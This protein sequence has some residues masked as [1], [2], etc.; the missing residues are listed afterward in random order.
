MNTL[1]SWSADHAGIVFLY[2]DG[3]APAADL[4]EVSG[5]LNRDTAYKDD[6][7][8]EEQVAKQ[9]NVKSFLHL[10]KQFMNRAS[11]RGLLDKNGKAFSEYPTSF[12]KMSLTQQALV[13]EGFYKNLE[14]VS[15]R[16]SRTDNPH[17][18]VSGPQP[19]AGQVRSARMQCLC[20]VLF[21]LLSDKLMQ[22][23]FSVF[24]AWL[25]DVFS[26]EGNDNVQYKVS[27]ID[28]LLYRAQ[29]VIRIMQKLQDSRAAHASE[30]PDKYPYR[31]EFVLKK[32]PLFS[33]AK[34]AAMDAMKDVVDSGNSQDKAKANPLT[35][36]QQRDA[37]KLPMLSPLSPLVRALT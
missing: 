22:E 24:V 29:T 26:A 30:E 16:S 8:L 1:Y 34:K 23:L 13:L 2:Q 17:G 18:N 12:V 25:Q 27:T 7:E 35:M 31:Q 32:H 10:I 6:P 21:V 28:Q 3:S 15:T 5:D 20:V 14:R 37:L 19:V 36:D 11:D 33:H 9:P 4:V